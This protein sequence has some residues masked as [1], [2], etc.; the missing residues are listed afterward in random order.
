MPISIKIYGERN[1]GTN[2]VQ[3]LLDSNFNVTLQPGTPHYVR[4]KIY[5]IAGRLLPR[6]LT[7]WAVTLLRGDQYY[8]R[9][10]ARDLG[11]KHAL[12]P[13]FP[14]GSNPYPP[15]ICF[16][17]LTKNPYAWLLSLHR[18]PYG[19]LDATIDL[20]KLAFTEFVQMPWKSNPR[21]NGPAEFT[22]AIVMWNEKAKSYL[23]LPKYGLTYH[24]RYED[25]VRSPEQFVRQIAEK[26]GLQQPAKIKIVMNSTKGDSQRY[27]DYR[28]YYTA[29]TWRARLS[30]DD[31]ATIN[32]WLDPDMVRIFG[33][34]IID[35]T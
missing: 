5:G 12:I 1:T 21:E 32:R 6:Q 31:I 24:A 22:N 25:V 4:R 7:A 15:G 28:D 26:F 14:A 23:R 13:D 11:W 27:E 3:A 10:F 20:P 9:L 30:A 19:M 2:F 16:V 35:S 33:Y 29:Q 18:R 34:E 17:T 8:A